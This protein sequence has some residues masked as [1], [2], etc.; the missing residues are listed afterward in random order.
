MSVAAVGGV[1]R[2]G[3]VPGPTSGGVRARRRWLGAL[4]LAACSEREPAPV[5]EPTYF[6]GL[7]RDAQ[8][9]LDPAY[10]DDVTPPGAPEILGVTV[11]AATRD[12]VQPSCDTTIS[13]A[14]AVR[15]TDD[16]A[17]ADRLGY[18]ASIESGI[19]VSP[20]IGVQN[21]VPLDG[22]VHITAETSFGAF[23]GEV[24]VVAV[25]LNGNVGPM[26]VRMVSHTP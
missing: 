9:A 14:I 26:T 7:P 20:S 22:R 16:R 1:T 4:L 5:D 2:G 19:D 15:A 3:G 12:P 25:D 18:F 6:C 13:I 24:G 21:A 10:R 11:T 23:F 8:H 17:P